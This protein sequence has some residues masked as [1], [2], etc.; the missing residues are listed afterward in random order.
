[1][2]MD[3]TGEFNILELEDRLEFAELCDGNCGCTNTGCTTTDGG[4]GVTVG[5]GGGGGGGGGG[6][7][8]DLQLEQALM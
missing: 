2:N 7:A 5:T 8:G 1:M 4:V 6:G 3:L